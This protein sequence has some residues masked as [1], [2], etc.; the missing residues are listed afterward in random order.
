MDI[1]TS[2]VT[3]QIAVMGL[4]ALALLVITLVL[5]SLALRHD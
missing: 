4:A 5:V 1:I 3:P 2:S